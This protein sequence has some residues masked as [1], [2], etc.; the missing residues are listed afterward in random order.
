MG[1]PDF[2]HGF[3]YDEQERVDILHSPFF[4]VAFGDDRD[5]N[6][7]V[8]R[9]LYQ[10]TLAIE[11]QLPQGHWRIIGHPSTSPN[12]AP[13]P[14]ASTRSFFLPTNTDIIARHSRTTD[15]TT[16]VATTIGCTIGAAG[17]AGPT[18]D[19][20]FSIICIIICIICI[21][22]IVPKPSNAGSGIVG[23][24]STLGS[25]FSA[26]AI[27]SRPYGI[28]LGCTNPPLVPSG[29]LVTITPGTK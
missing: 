26:G 22:S 11:D 24:F 23:V 19:C 15:T 7:Y 16:G 29:T 14:A 1:D 6:E 21:C 3:R 12:L 17:Q 20:I 5:A 18:K 9:I 4:D 25:L 13:N 2:D 28:Q 8:D 27:L 10:L